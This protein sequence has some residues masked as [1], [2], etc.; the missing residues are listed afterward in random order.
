MFAQL[1]D[2]TQMHTLYAR[3]AVW[4]EGAVLADLIIA[5]AM[6]YLVSFTATEDMF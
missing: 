5:G 2:V 1:A 6:L 4:L 3:N